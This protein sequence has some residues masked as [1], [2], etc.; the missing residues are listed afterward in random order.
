MVDIPGQNIG[1]EDPRTL[2]ATNNL[3]WK[4]GEQ[5]KP[6]GRSDGSRIGIRDGSQSARAGSCQHAQQHWQAGSLAVFTS[7]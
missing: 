5:R 2:A 3:A 7:G 4:S 1:S 6:R